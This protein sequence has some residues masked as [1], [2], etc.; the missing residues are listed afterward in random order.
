MEEKVDKLLLL[1]IKIKICKFNLCVSFYCF[2]YYLIPAI[3]KVQASR[4]LFQFR[5][6][7]L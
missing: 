7:L 2:P 4:R 6:K 1:K 3:Q 5:C